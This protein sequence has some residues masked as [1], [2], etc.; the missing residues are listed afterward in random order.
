MSEVQPAD[1]LEFWFDG[2]P[3][4]R[5]KVWFEKNTDFDDACG[6][7]RRAADAANQ[8]LLESWAATPRGALALVLLLDQFPRNL[9]RGSSL[10]FA[11]DARARSVAAAAVARGV[12][13]ALTSVE[14]MF[15]Y[16]PF[17]HSETLADQD[18][19]VRLF[20][21]LRDGCGNDLTNY[22]ER[23]RDV[24]RRF[25]RFPHRNAVLGRTSTADEEAYL[26]EPGAGF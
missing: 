21:Q 1:V 17:E 25:G 11:S 19:S 3:A 5:R 7:F 16:L 26:A 10:A 6:R 2:D 24:I 20:G 23:H 9:H 14:R 15:L 4:A 13:L 12:D 22:A 18:E 8:G